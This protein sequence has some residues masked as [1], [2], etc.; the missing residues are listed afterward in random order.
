VP[1]CDQRCHTERTFA[2]HAVHGSLI[3]LI[4]F[5]L[6]GVAS[7]SFSVPGAR[8]MTPG[9][10]HVPPHTELHRYDARCAILNPLT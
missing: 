3:V 5:H 9:A 6:N 7:P 2:N 4:P 10:T 8:M 1:P